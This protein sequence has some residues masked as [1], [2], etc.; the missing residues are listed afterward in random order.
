MP[1]ARVEYAVIESLPQIGPPAYAVYGVLARHADRYGR[2]HPGIDRIARMAGIGRRTAQRAVATLAAAGL[3]E[4]RRTRHGNSYRLPAEHYDAP[5]AA[6]PDAPLAAPPDAP[7]AAPPD[8][9]LAAPKQEPKKQKPEKQEGETGRVDRVCLSS[10]NRWWPDT[11]RIARHI[12]K[13]VPLSRASREQRLADWTVVAKVA[14]LR[15]CG[16]ISEH[17]LADSLE[18]V[19]Q[20]QPR[21]P[22]AYWQT[23]L[24]ERLA[25]SGG[26]LWR[27][28]ARVEIPAA[29]LPSWAHD[30]G[31]RQPTNRRISA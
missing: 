21:R 2:C 10:W 6:P 4:V 25:E 15:A 17:T 13:V 12:A 24:A 31:G 19:R 3:V 27:M 30:A 7:L 8:A 11:E 26:D 23:V 29:D 1:Y 22:V 9:P 20:T 18:A 5:L 28:L 16:R 14:Y